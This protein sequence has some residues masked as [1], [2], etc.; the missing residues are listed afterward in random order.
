[1]K[2]FSSEIIYVYLE[3]GTLKTMS[4]QPATKSLTAALRV[5]TLTTPSDT[6]NKVVTTTA[7]RFQCIYIL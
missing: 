5:V 7:L 1:M 2:P 6:S 3:I 4:R